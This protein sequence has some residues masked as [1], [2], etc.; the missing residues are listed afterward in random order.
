MLS[1][2]AE[3]L[4]ITT[5]GNYSLIKMNHIK[6][7]LIRINYFS[8]EAKKF[9]I[10]ITLNFIN[11]GAIQVILG[12]YILKLGYNEK[13][14]GLVVAARILAMG[15]MAIPVGLLNKN[16]GSKKILLLG[17]LLAASSVLLQTYL[18]DKLI[19]LLLNFL[20]GTAY[21]IFFVTIGPFLSRNSTKKDRNELFSLNF[22]LMTVG[23]MIGCFLAGI[24]P[25]FLALTLPGINNS[26]LYS[27]KFVL[28]I[29]ALFSL[30]SVIPVLLMNVSKT[31][32]KVKN[33]NFSFKGFNK[34]KVGKLSIYQF[35]LGA[36]GGF[37]TPFFSIFLAQQFNASTEEIG[38]IMLTYRVIIAAAIFL[39]PYL[40]KNVGKV[41][42]VGFAQIGS[43]P[44]LLTIV[45][46]PNFAIVYFTF[47]LRGALMGM[48]QPI[49]SDFAMEI[50]SSKSK[51]MT[52]S[53]MRTSKSLARSGSA[54]LGGWMIANYGYEVTYF[55]TF[56]MYLLGA[57]LFLKSF[58][59]A[60]RKGV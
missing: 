45:L 31:D 22:I 8:S 55:L 16:I 35:L 36:G 42:S 19:I 56:T 50:T 44:F 33:E 10:L 7:Y 26:N 47:L 5:G 20:Y 24:L 6:N 52:S 41:K 11:L 39:T 46:I 38:F 58:K 13:F 2:I 32:K 3:N 15:L 43:L 37:I 12:L 57:L 51:T 34:D 40:T 53:I 21:A 48:T 23:K 29:L 27:F 49:A 28:I 30:F 18:T 9:L 17:A 54:S 60:D 59:K 25:G 4:L 1:L 14:F